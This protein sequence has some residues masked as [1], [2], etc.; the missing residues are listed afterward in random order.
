M[1]K[2]DDTQLVRFV[3]GYVACYCVSALSYHTFFEQV[4]VACRAV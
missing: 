1:C 3:V 4:M 2:A